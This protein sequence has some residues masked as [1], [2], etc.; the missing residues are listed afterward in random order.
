MKRVDLK[1]E[2]HG[3]K[4]GAW[5]YL[6]EKEKPPV[7]VMAHGFGADKLLRLPAFAEKF[8]EKGLAAF[9]FDYRNFGDSTGEPRNWISPKRHLEDWKAA[10][11]FVRGLKE[12]DGKRMGL[13]GS[14]FSGGHVL[15]T[16][17]EVSGISAV[18]SQVP[19]VDGIATSSLY[20]FG[21]IAQAIAHA[22]LDV[23]SSAFLGR[24]HNVPIVSGPSQFALLNTPE[25]LPGFESLKPPNYTMRNFAPARIV[26][27]LPFYRPVKFVSKIPCPV[28]II[29]AEKDT[30]IP[31]ASVAKTASLIKNSR[32]ESFPVGHFDVYTGELFEK[33][34]KL[35]ADFL[36][37]HLMK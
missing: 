27:S 15:K 6:P 18:V 30:L 5:L 1:F 20:P 26:L 22:I 37:E 7:V 9:V 11:D 23:L 36:A 31:P 3:E 34:S 24:P 12:V 35:E 2:S 28:L 29:R 16:A 19:F 14:S 8:V 10:I 13:W 4:C 32:T 33:V 21:F 25:C 17:A